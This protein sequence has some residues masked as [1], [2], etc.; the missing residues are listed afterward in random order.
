MGRNGKLRNIFYSFL[1][2]DKLYRRKFVLYR[3]RLVSRTVLKQ[4]KIFKVIQWL[5]LSLCL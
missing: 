1:L 2:K 3:F 5:H 4:F